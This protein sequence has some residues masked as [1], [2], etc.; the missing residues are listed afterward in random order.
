MVYLSGG[1]GRHGQ[2]GRSGAPS[3]GTASN[4]RARCPH[5]IHE[6]IHDGVLACALA[7]EAMIDHSTVRG[8]AGASRDPDAAP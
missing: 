3:G 7:E 2:H 6:V 1:D 5:G 8:T 4:V